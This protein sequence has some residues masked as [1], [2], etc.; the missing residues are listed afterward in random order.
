MKRFFPVFLLAALLLLLCTTTVAQTSK[1]VSSLGVKLQAYP[2]GLIPTVSYT[3]SVS[4][5]NTLTFYAAYNATDRQDFGEHDNEE[6]G[7]A[8]F[9][10][11]WRYYFGQRHNG[12]HLGARVDL[13]FLE[14]DW[15]DESPVRA[16][17]TEITVLQPTAQV[18]Y[19]KLFSNDRIAAR[20]VVALGAEINI[21]T[22]GEAVGEGAI[23]L[24]GLGASYRF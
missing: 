21:E 11:S 13:W 9:G 8:G 3:K 6:G 5:N 19:T 14:I 24:F 12:F 10:A 20:A 16:G 15:L 22:K 4:P 23:L 2:A 7:G 17:V 1:S 18:G